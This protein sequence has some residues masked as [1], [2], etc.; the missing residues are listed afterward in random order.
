MIKLLDLLENRILIPRR[1]EERKKIHVRVLTGEI[2]QYIENGSKGSIRMFDLTEPLPIL[3]DLKKV[4]GNLDLRNLKTIPEGFNP[5]VTGYFYVNSVRKPL[6]GGFN[7]TVGGTLDLSNV[8]SVPTGFNPTVGGNLYLTRLTSI[9]KEFNPTVGGNL[10]LTSLTSIPK[11]FNPTVE[12]DLR[13]TY[14]VKIEKGWNPT[15]IKSRI[16]IGGEEYV[17]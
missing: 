15:N 3:R 14:S 9:P 12:G 13:L 16:L 2:K 6:P 5:T 8:P 7:P 11:E 17:V 1:V 4:D 10:I